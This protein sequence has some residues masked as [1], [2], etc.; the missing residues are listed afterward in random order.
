MAQISGAKTHLQELEEDILT[1]LANASGEILN[2]DVLINSLTA[3][4]AT[5]DDVTR[6]LG[7]A[8]ITSKAINNSRQR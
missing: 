6:Q 2:D 5:S 1:Q 3:S 4:K 8:E 7:D